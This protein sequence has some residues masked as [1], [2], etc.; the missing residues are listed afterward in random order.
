MLYEGYRVKLYNDEV[1]LPGDVSRRGKLSYLSEYLCLDSETSHIPITRDENGSIIED[2]LC[3]WIYQWACASGDTIWNGRT[4]EQLIEFLKNVIEVNDINEDK[5]LVVFVHNLAYDHEY[6]VQYLIEAFGVPKL[7]ATGKH[8]IIQASYDNGL[9]FRCTYR[10]TNKS[11]EKWSK[12]L[13]TKH[14]KLIGFV[15]YDDIHYQDSSL[16]YKDYAYQWNDVIVMREALAIQLNMYNDNIST[17]P[18]TSTGYIRRKVQR[19]Y[20][21]ANDKNGNKERRNFLSTRMT[22][23]VYSLHRA[24]MAGGLTHGNRHIANTKVS[25]NQF[26]PYIKHRDFESHYPTQQKIHKFPVGKWILE[27]RY[28]DKHKLDQEYFHYIMKTKAILMRVVIKN[29]RVKSNKVVLPYASLDKF[30]KC[31]ESG[32]RFTQDNG[33]ILEM[34][35]GSAEVVLNEIDFKWLRRQ[36]TFEY[37]I[38]EL[39]SCKLAPL[40][41]YILD[42]VDELYADKTNLKRKV[43]ELKEAKASDYDIIEAELNLLICKQLLNGIY[44]MSATDPVRDE[45]TLNE[46]GEWTTVAGNVEAML[47][48]YYKSVK[49]NMRYSFGCWTTAYARDELMSFYEYIQEAGG[50]FLYADTDSIFYLSNDKVEQALADLNQSL[51]DQAEREGFYTFLDNGEK[52]YYN[53]FDDENDNIK[54]FK[55]LHAKCYG[56]VN[57]DDRLNITIAGVPARKLMSDGTYYTREDE[58]GSIDNLR[59]DFEFIVNGGSG[60]KYVTH[61]I[62]TIN[63]EGHKISYSNSAIIYDTTKKLSELEIYDIEE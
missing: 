52:H 25:V 41:Q 16:T 14:K 17:I 22:P 18:L 42:V 23:E 31:Y 57:A 36:Y 3:G 32:T 4:P 62:D 33:R 38:I 54:E 1:V 24:E 11:L 55:Y 20:K 56:V 47:N 48:T 6:L 51:R 21:K 5:K 44:G 8:K 53:R 50:V 63:I 61:N 39:W 35:G 59:K 19:N 13:G 46:S 30:T 12:D 9:V 10:L 34:Y 15:D 58:L 37:A 28:T 29:L 40:P 49:N 27:Y 26:Y 45:Y 60:C 7:I 43:R 2:D